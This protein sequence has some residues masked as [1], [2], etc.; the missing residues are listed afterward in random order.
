MKCNLLHIALLMVST[1]TLY[2]CDR[3]LVSLNYNPIYVPPPLYADFEVLD[4]A[5]DT[6]IRQT[7]ADQ[8]VRKVEQLVTLRCSNAG[9][10]TLEGLEHFAW[11]QKLD[12]SANQISNAVA[13][14]KL[15]HLQYLKL[16]ENPEL[17]CA[18]LPRADTPTA[19]ELLAPQHCR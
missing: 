4:E 15:P 10:R 17:N 2:G 13:L 8:R 14:R 1:A 12:L 7:I 18:E 3:Y 5:L 6:C 16:T 9:I 11:L 19:P